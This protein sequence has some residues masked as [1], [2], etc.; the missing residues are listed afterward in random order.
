M[1]N[2]AVLSC[3]V[4]LSQLFFIARHGARGVL[5]KWRFVTRFCVAILFSLTFSTIPKPRKSRHNFQ[6]FEIESRSEIS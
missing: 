1:M 6:K 4:L 5:D 2:A 3:F